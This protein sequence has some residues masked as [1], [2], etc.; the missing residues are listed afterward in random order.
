MTGSRLDPGESL[1]RRRT[2]CRRAVVCAVLTLVALSSASLLPGCT[3]RG[4]GAGDAQGARGDSV[5]LV[6]VDTVRADKLGCY[7]GPVAT[8]AFDRLA[9]EGL[10]FDRAVSAVPLTLPSHTTILTG[11]LPPHHGVRLNGAGR[12]PDDV[13]TLATRLSAA[14]YA[15]G[16]FLGAFVLDHRFGLAR[17]FASY[18]DEIDRG[19][20]HGTDALEAERPGAVVVDRALAWLAAQPKDKPFFLWVHL[21]DAHAPYTPPEPFRA[22]YANPYDGEIAGVDAQLGR[23]LDALDARGAAARTIVTVLGDH[24]ESLGEH[25]EDT[26][27]LLLYESTLRVPWLVRAPGALAAGRVVSA[28]VSL[29]DVTPTV[30]A[31]LGVPGGERALDGRDASAPP[32]EDEARTARRIYSETE[33]P[34]T[35]GWAGI[36]ALR[37]GTRKYI[38]APRPELYDLDRDP[39]ELHDLVAGGRAL[40]EFE[41]ALA[42]LQRNASTVE[43]TVDAET[44]AR[45]GSL[46]YV[47]APAPAPSAG[48]SGAAGLRDPKDAAPLFRRFEAAHRDLGAGRADAAAKT[49]DEL[50]V[51]DPGNPVFLSMLA[52][53]EKRRGRLTRAIALHE[54]VLARRPDDVH[55]R[56]ELALVL[57]EAGRP[58]DA[59][60]ALMESLRRNAQFPEAHNALGIALAAE[61]RLDEALSAFRRALE[62]DPRASRTHN[63]AGNVLRDL[64]RAGE[65]EREYHAA[66]ALDPRYADAHTGLG[67]LAL[68]RNDPAAALAEF[69]AA[70]ALAPHEYDILVN[71]G[72]ALQMLGRAAEARE[73]YRTVIASAAAPEYAPSRAAARQLLAQLE[74][75]GSNATVRH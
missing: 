11:L 14:G 8:P 30:L 42:A 39:R 2:G 23:L 25:G 67:A 63:N 40:P 70:L 59:R 51:A 21:Y 13:P 71:R 58:A 41:D 54:Q 50:L 17:G 28:P 26:H 64:G 12:L 37:E 9:R 18:D 31:L 74:G 19:E 33:Y 20:A 4:R 29:A 61:G 22:R 3:G 10:R 7:G 32:R 1:L 60:A 44:R 69:D 34:R 48:G 66:L 73:A 57:Q 72:I 6:T 5:L 24:G 16:A 56:Y 46:G 65:A 38:R 15:T 55:E 62:L 52:Q 35:Y 45:L 43:S 49:L 27:G 68:A 53:A 47:S 75:P 36:A